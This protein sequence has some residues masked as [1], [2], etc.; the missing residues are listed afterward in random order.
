MKLT[1]KQSATLKRLIEIHGT[2]IIMEELEHLNLDSYEA[3]DNHLHHVAT[4]EEVDAH[5]SR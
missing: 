2:D 4:Q 3:C 5:Y 1:T